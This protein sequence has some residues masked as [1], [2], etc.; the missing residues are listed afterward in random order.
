M[1]ARHATTW[2]QGVILG[3]AA[4]TSQ[5]GGLEIAA[6]DS[7]C[8]KYVRRVAMFLCFGAGRK[9]TKWKAGEWT[10]ASGGRCA[11]F[12]PAIGSLF[13][14]RTSMISSYWVLCE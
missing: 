6:E 10:A 4:S 7:S 1:L 2:A 12:E 3:A 11:R 5:S 13:A 8:D 9:R 14:L